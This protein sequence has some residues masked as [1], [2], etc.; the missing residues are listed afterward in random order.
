MYWLAPDALTKAYPK[1]SLLADSN[2][3]RHCPLKDEHEDGW[4]SSVCKTE[5][6]ETE[7]R[8]HSGLQ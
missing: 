3:M 2:P 5:I 7:Y 8:S 4:F 6:Q 1:T